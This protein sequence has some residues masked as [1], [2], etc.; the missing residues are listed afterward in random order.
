MGILGFGRVTKLEDLKVN[1]LKKE[2]NKI[3]ISVLFKP[4][5]NLE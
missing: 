1:D 4:S 3:E 5:I 2:V